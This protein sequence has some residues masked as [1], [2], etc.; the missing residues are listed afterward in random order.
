MAAGTLLREL[1]RDVWEPFRSAYGKLDAAGFM[2]VHSP[3]LIRAGGPTKKVQGYAEYAAEIRDWFARVSAN[4]DSL[5][6]GFRFLERLAAG[7]AASERGVYRIAAMRAGT[8]K[9]F[10]GRFHVF[11]RRSDGRWRIVVDYDA[12]DGA[13]EEAFTSGVALDDVAAFEG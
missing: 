10:H 2:A 7:D 3:D 5:D 1:N 4:G 13:T 6:I 9:V 8:P 12:D 11:C